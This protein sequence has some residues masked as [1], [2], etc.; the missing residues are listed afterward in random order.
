[1]SRAVVIGAGIGGLT[2][3]VAL[4]RRGWQVTVLERA[5]RL[6]AVG[7]GLAVAAN[8]LKALDTIDLGDEVRRLSRIQGTGGLRTPHGRWLIQTSEQSAAARYGDSIAI[9]LRATLVDLLADRVRDLRLGTPVTGVDA[10]NGVVRT[11]GGEFEADLV[12]AGDGINSATR[13]ALFPGHPAPVYSGVTAWRVLVPQPGGVVQST[14][15][16]GR[17]LV[18]GVHPL[19]DDLVYLYATDLAPAGEPHGDERAGLLRRFGDWHQPIPALLESARRE[20]VIRNDVYY[21]GT[22]LP[23]MHRGRVALLGDAAHP[24]TPNLGQ[25]ACQAIEDAIVLAA[26]A[27]DLTAYTEARLARTAKV[28]AQS[29]KICRATKVRHPLAVRLRE[30]GM[31]LAG[32]LSSDLMLRSMDEVLGW[33]PP[34]SAATGQGRAARA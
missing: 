19:A 24:M 8:A 17:G 3:A 10:E 2:A 30:T 23:A 6:E 31:A 25:G 12:V 11:Q 16:W 26:T 14:E 18:A 22:P 20:D 9:M 7:S 29:T 4:E 32:R 21:L 33:T 34:E 1:M 15:T 28:V 27:P 5:E 13:A